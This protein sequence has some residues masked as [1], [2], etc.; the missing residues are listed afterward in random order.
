LQEIVDLSV[1][2]ADHNLFQQMGV[3]D[4]WSAPFE[5]ANAEASLCQY[6]IQFIS[7]DWRVW[8]PY[9]EWG[10]RYG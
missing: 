1:S 9:P 2:L 7:I 4:A 10:A 5:F 3:F 8:Q 6:P